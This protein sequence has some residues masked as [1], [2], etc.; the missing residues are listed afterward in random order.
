M[1]AE[2]NRELTGVMEPFDSFWEAPHD[3]E[4]GYRTF[5]LFYRANYVPHLPEDRASEILVISCGPGYFLKVLSEL[6]YSRAQ[7]IDSDPEKVA[8][9]RAKG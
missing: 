8:M 2:P 5:G 9:A 7:G 6:G 3:I 1:T 4:K